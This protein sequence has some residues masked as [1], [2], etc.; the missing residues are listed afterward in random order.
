MLFV[1]LVS[2]GFLSSFDYA[3]A[4]RGFS[5][6]ASLQNCDIE[7]V[8]GSGDLSPNPSPGRRGAL[9]DGVGDFEGLAPPMLGAGGLLW[10]LIS[11][12]DAIA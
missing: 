10:F 1:S 4:Q 7:S 12:N 3:I 8:G 5:R 11:F 6:I 9:T 2:L